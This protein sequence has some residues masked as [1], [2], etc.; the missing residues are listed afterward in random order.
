MPSRSVDAA[1]WGRGHLRR[2]GAVGARTCDAPDFPARDLEGGHP[3]TDHMMD[4]GLIAV[5]A[6]EVGVFW[7]FHA[8]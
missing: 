5:S 3:F 7:S 2:H 1:T 4:L 8:N 6:D